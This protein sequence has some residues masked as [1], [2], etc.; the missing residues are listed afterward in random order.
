MNF[1]SNKKNQQIVYL[2]MINI[3]PIVGVV[4][5]KW[6]VFDFFAYYILETAILGLFWIIKFMYVWLTYKKYNIW[7]Y[8]LFFFLY[9]FLGLFFAVQGG[10]F[11]FGQFVFLDSLYSNF[12]WFGKNTLLTM[13]I[14]IWLLIKTKYLWQLIYFSLL[15]I[16]FLKKQVIVPVQQTEPIKQENIDISFKTL[17]VYWRII[18]MNIV[19]MIGLFIYMIS[20]IV[21]GK[22]IVTFILPLLVFICL[23]VYL[24]YKDIKELSDK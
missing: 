15:Q 20:D 21:S 6:N 14:N 3:L 23:K 12:L 10:V 19:I 4:F 8:P 5:L 17:G 22:S 13:L 1:M 16:I 7:Q 11:L 2:I 9:L 18:L 24:W